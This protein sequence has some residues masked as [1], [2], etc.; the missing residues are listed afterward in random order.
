MYHFIPTVNGCASHE[1]ECNNT[2]CIPSFWECDGF[3][4]CGDGSDEA[5]DLCD[6][7]C[8]EYQYACGNGECIPDF[9]ECDEIA[10]C[11]DGTDEDNHCCTY[12]LRLSKILRF[13]MQ[14]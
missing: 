9:W 13:F 7:T 3:D 12:K 2:N 14:T 5:E 6:G 4:D 10:D 8:N 11:S 1:F